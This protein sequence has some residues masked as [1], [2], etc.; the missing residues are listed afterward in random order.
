MGI[1]NDFFNFLIYFLSIFNSLELP[2][3]VSLFLNEFSWVIYL[4]I[5]NKKNQNLNP[6]VNGMFFF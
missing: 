2:I 1:S 5:F 3:C 6:I 4:Y